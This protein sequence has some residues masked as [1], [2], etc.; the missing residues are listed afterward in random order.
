VAVGNLVAALV[1]GFYMWRTH[2]E[3]KHELTWALSGGERR[4]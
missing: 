1:M 3:L 4:E 2:P